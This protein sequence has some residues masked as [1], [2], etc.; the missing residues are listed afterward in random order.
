MNEAGRIPVHGTEVCVCV[1]FCYFA[2]DMQRQIR[3]ANFY[4]STGTWDKLVPEDTRVN[5]LL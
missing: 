2:Q 1:F 3:P 5:Q 4:T